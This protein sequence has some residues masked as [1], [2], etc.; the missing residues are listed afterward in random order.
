MGTQGLLTFARGHHYPE[1]SECTPHPQVLLVCKTFRLPLSPERPCMGRE[2]GYRGA[3]ESRGLLGDVTLS[4]QLK[5][6]NARVPALGHG[7]QLLS[8]GHGGEHAG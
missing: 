2:S 7:V 1:S 8:T 3:K 4:T 5:S 6:M